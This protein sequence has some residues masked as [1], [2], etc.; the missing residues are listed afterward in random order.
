MTP[1]DKATSALLDFDRVKVVP[2]AADESMCRA[3]IPRADTSGWREKYLAPKMQ[4]YSRMVGAAP[5]TG[6][7]PVRRD[8]LDKIIHPDCYSFNEVADARGRILR[9]ME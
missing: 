5:D 9:T 3:A 2:V 1:Q 6:Y 8:D 4:A 7:V